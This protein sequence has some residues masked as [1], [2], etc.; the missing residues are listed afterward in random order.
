MIDRQA[1]LVWMRRPLP[2]VSAGAPLCVHCGVRAA[3]TDDG[4][5]TACRPC[6]FRLGDRAC[7]PVR[8]EDAEL[9]E[10]ETA[11]R[12]VAYVVSCREHRLEWMWTRAW[13]SAGDD[14]LVAPETAWR[15]VGDAYL[16]A[17]RHG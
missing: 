14:Q 7:R 13:P 4:D 2:A 1:L 11:H 8:F 12:E 10:L 6:I 5:L 15:V 3:I 9:A 16:I 17:A